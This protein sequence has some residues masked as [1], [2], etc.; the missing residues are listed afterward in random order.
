MEDIL[1]NII[2]QLNSLDEKNKDA[3]AKIADI[4]TGDFAQQLYK[5]KEIFDKIDPILDEIINDLPSVP[6]KDISAKILD[7]KQKLIRIFK[8]FLSPKVAVKPPSPPKKT[9]GVKPGSL[10]F[11]YKP[12][13][14]PYGVKPSSMT[15]GIDPP[16]PLPL[17]LGKIPTPTLLAK[18]AEAAKADATKAAEA[19]ARA[20]AR[21]EAAEVAKADA[22]AK[23][24]ADATKAAQ[25]RARAQALFA[26]KPPVKA[27]SLPSGVK[28]LLMPL[29]SKVKP[30]SAPALVKAPVKIP[31]PKI[32]ITPPS[33]PSE[34]RRPSFQL[35]DRRPSFQLEDRRPSF[36][37]EDRPRSVHTVRTVPSSPIKIR[38]DL[39]DEYKRIKARDYD[40][41]RLHYSINQALYGTDFTP[42]L[43]YKN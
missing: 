42:Y 26:V 36:Q 34:D 30:T 14:L 1:E 2:L 32:P 9:N 3:S 11:G 31:I 21:A 15:F 27:S 23:A 28:P 4:I 12:T 33:V 18:A 6:D 38:K 16:L 20:D 13:Q 41:F 25:A 10:P 22:R 8:S 35:E 37:L 7:Y 24:K 5:Q 40:I 43:R 29:S 17:N 19:Q 39:K